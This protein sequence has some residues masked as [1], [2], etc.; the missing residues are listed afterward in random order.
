MCNFFSFN[1]DGKEF[2]WF[3]W[4][5]RKKVLA[6]KLD[7]EPD[8]HTSIADYFGFKGKKED[9]LNKYEYN[10]LTKKFRVDQ[11]NIKDDSRKAEV[12][13]KSLDFKEVCPL[14]IV[15]PIIHPF[16]LG[17]VKPTK[18]DI[19][20]LKVWASVWASVGDSVGDSVRDSVGASVRDSV[21]DSVRASVWDSVRDSVWDSVGASVRDSVGAS[22]GDSVWASVGASVGDSVWA[23]TSG[24]FDLAKWQH[25]KHTKGRNPYQPLITLW[26]KG[27]VPSFD[28]KKWQ[29][30]S[31]EKAKIVWAGKVK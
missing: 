8:S 5:L 19:E 14:L 30:H 26:E 23:Y 9:S 7:Y 20:L 28:G 27:L 16:K 12:W 6:G 25:I 10:P 24:Y 11:I 18:K 15:K 17:V 31:G 21:R 3:D 4:E 2:Y 22:V 13:V 29:L 1:S